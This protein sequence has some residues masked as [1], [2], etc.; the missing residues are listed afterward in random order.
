MFIVAYRWKA[1]VD[2]KLPYRLRPTSID[3][4]LVVFR[5]IVDELWFLSICLVQMI[6]EVTPTLVQLPRLACLSAKAVY[7]E[8]RSV[9]LASPAYRILACIIHFVF[10]FGLNGLLLQPAKLT[11][12][13][14]EVIYRETHKR[15]RQGALLSKL[16]N[17]ILALII[18]H[19]VFS[20]EP[21]G[22]PIALLSFTYV[23]RHWRDITIHLP[24]L[25]AAIST[26]LMISRRAGNLE[27][28]KACVARSASQ[29][30]SVVLSTANGASEYLEVLDGRTERWRT[31]SFVMWD[32]RFDRCPGSAAIAKLRNCAFPRLT[33]LELSYHFRDG[34]QLREKTALFFA[35]INAPNLE[36]LELTNI[37]PQQLPLAVP[38]RMPSSLTALTARYT[39]RSWMDDWEQ[40]D[41]NVWQIDGLLIFLQAHSSITE[42]NLF[43]NVD[44]LT[45]TPLP[46]TILPHVKT[47]SLTI[48]D[49]VE[50]SVRPLLRALQLPNC[51]MFSLDIVFTSANEA[52]EWP[53][54][55]PWTRSSCSVNHFF[56]TLLWPI[57]SRDADSG[58]SNLSFAK[59]TDFSLKVVAE[60]SFMK[61]S[62][63]FPFHRFPLLER[64]HINT[65]LTVLPARS[66][67]LPATGSPSGGRGW[68]KIPLRR[69]VLQD[70]ANMIDLSWLRVLSEH[71]DHDLLENVFIEGSFGSPTAAR[72]P[73]DVLRK[74]FD[75]RKITHDGAMSSADR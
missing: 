59:V 54:T 12:H 4:F 68:F 63:R 65:K 36:H 1:K 31:L 19:A 22:R 64:L 32:N 17:E 43:L 53:R 69:L 34:Y 45:L 35:Q 47:F 39:E 8:L 10:A 28:Y 52:G 66:A 15:R 57:S 20:V 58:C 24:G 60:P 5:D 26:E 48:E 14:A 2:Y 40:S 67:I 16:P 49:T 9:P 13:S 38:S 70:Y 18:E 51:V 27:W 3:D 25:W 33:K 29:D 61:R 42:L 11:Y 62:F 41:T 75:A 21:Q 23:C 73:K 72:G 55:I 37:V 30:L 74:Y 6:I 44:W 46:V 7:H 71:V 56:N 50:E